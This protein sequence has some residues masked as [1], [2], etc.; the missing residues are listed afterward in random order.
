MM[1]VWR[2]CVVVLLTAML[3]QGAR[4]AS[5]VAD[6]QTLGVNSA[7][8]LRIP[9]ARTFTV[10][11]AGQVQVTLRDL[12]TPL[13]VATGFSKLKAIV[14]LGGTKVAS[15]AAAGTVQ[16]AATPGVYKI[17]VVGTAVAPAGIFD[18]L[19]ASGGTSLLQFSDGIEAVPTAPNPAQSTLDTDIT[20]ASP[21]TYQLM[22][23]DRALPAALLSVDVLL[24]RQGAVPLTISGP[25]SS[26]CSLTFNVPSAGSYNLIVIATAADPDKA[27]VYSVAVIGGPSASTVY[28][29]TQAVGRMPAP[30]AL[31]LAAGSGT[32]QLADFSTPVALAKLGALLA[33]GANTVALQSGAGATNFG[34]ASAGDAS[35]FVYRKPDAGGAGS[36]GISI[37]QSGSVVLSDAR[38]VPEGFDATASVG[39]YRHTFTVTSAGTYT[40]Q[41]KDLAFPV[42]FSTLRGVLVQNGVVVQSLTRGTASTPNLAAGA[43]TALVFG[44]PSTQAA[45]SLYGISVMPASGAGV[46]DLAQGVGGLI[47]TRAFGIPTAGSYDLA[48]DDLQFPD[49]FAELAVAVTEGSTLIGQIFGGGK[50]TFSAAAGTHAVSLLPRPAAAAEYATWGFDVSTT[51]P[52]PTLSLTSSAA[53]VASGGSV[54][55]TWSATNAT[56]CTA[57]GG[58]AGTKAISGTESSAAQQVNTTYTLTC[59]GLGGN[60]IKSVTV[61]ITAVQANGSGGGGQL[62]G[63]LLALL[64]SFGVAVLARRRGWRTG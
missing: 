20:V 23:T 30:Q 24:L 42:L 29:T 38:P 54:T 51:P 48:V 58:W 64:A 2:S 32:L 4:A 55:L 45:N 57:S 25:C 27:G 13:G 7:A 31:T 60:A 9:D 22:L 43:A 46:L 3:G 28:S 19:V 14:T 12:G 33:Q 47:A 6:A 35:L 11:T 44:T 50:I 16:F 56:Q 8:S 1:H 61:G 5:L 18:V 39:G 63:P 26:T 37:L 21:G 49:P 15:L 17:Q 10:Q 52:A 59:I 34:T 40:A 62:D 36:Y 53:N 41:L